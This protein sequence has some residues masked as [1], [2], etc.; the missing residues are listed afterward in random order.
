MWKRALFKRRIRTILSH[1]SLRF[2][3]QLLLFFS[4]KKK[5]QAINYY[6]VPIQQ[7]ET[8]GEQ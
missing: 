5:S 6:Y 8:R 3:G 2:D 1:Q 4:E 7:D